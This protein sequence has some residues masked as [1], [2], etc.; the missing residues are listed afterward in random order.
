MQIT[1]TGEK[2]ELYL[3]RHPGRENAM[4]YGDLFRA[5]RLPEG[6]ALQQRLN[7]RRRSDRRK[8]REPRIRVIYEDKQGAIKTARYWMTKK[9]AKAVL[10]EHESREK[11]RECKRT[12]LAL[13]KDN[14]WQK[15]PELKP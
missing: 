15:R 12:F 4:A 7:E 9:D 10:A 1:C 14:T 2:A 6:T 11:L 13:L 3:A 5:L 8:G